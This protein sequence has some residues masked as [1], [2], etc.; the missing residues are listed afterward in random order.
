MPWII[1][2]QEI[3]LPYNQPG[4]LTGYG[5]AADQYDA[6]VAIADVY[7]TGGRQLG[8]RECP[9]ILELFDVKDIAQ[10]PGFFSTE[11]GAMIITEATKRIIERHDA[12]Q[13]QLIP[14]N[15][16]LADQVQAEKTV[17][18]L[19]VYQHLP[20]IDPTSPSIKIVKGFDRK[21]RQKLDLTQERVTLRKD[22]N[23]E[24]NVWRDATF[25]AALVLSNEL[26]TA[27]SNQLLLS[28]ATTFAAT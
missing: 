10:I 2:T 6:F 8:E 3:N 1:N 12:E 20:S 17:Y 16:I 15:L 22:L 27:L 26:Y 19:N 18:L 5:I 24:V 7:K 13:H 21:E 25:P 14:L 4:R 23:S 28:A 11:N 9:Q